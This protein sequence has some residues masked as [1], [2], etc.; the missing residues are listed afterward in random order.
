MSGGPGAPSGPSTPV[1]TQRDVFKL[2][3]GLEEIAPAFGAHV[4]LTGGL[5]YKLGKRKDADILFYSIRQVDVI[6]ISGLLNSMKE[7]GFT[8]ISGPY[9]NWLYKAEYEGKPVDLFFPEEP[10]PDAWL[11]I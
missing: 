8:A 2:C 7:I 3:V 5:L 6:D 1:W 11:G 4:A 10:R 9:H